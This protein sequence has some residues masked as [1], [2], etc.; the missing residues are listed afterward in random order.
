MTAF[1]F[2][3]SQVERPLLGRFANLLLSPL[4][5]T[6]FGRLPRFSQKGAE[7]GHSCQLPPHWERPVTLKPAILEATKLAATKTAIGPIA[8]WQVFTSSKTKADIN[9]VG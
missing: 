5:S 8:D 7:L 6:G 4:R 2:A 1:G 9:D 3:C